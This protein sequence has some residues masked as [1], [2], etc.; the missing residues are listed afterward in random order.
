MAE[1]DFDIWYR[2]KSVNKEAWGCRPA[3]WVGPEAGEI[4][5]EVYTL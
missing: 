1:K 2:R 5:K 3:R 4:P